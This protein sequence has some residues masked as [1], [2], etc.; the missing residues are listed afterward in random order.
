MLPPIFRQRVIVVVRQRGVYS[1]KVTT[2]HYILKLQTKTMT[3]IKNEEQIA[4]LKQQRDEVGE[5]YAIRGK[6][7]GIQW[8]GKPICANW[9]EQ[10]SRIYYRFVLHDFPCFISRFLTAVII[11]L[12]SF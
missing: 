4:R 2:F 3:E 9:V 10:S 11:F 8:H 5:L 1:T 7:I 6:P 12:K